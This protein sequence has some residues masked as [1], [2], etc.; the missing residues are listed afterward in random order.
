[1]I[2]YNHYLK[3]V[4]KI[5]SEFKTLF[6]LLV[7][8]DMIITKYINKIHPRICTITIF[9]FCSRCSFAF[10]CAVACLAV[11][12]GVNVATGFSF[13]GTGILGGVIL[14]IIHV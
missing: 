6:S 13:T 3:K 2:M 14:K 8:F 11:C 7:G 5:L 10:A 12:F 4:V 1:M 9:V